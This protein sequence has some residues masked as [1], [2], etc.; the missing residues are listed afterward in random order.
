[1]SEHSEKG[2]LVTFDMDED[3]ND[4]PGEYGEDDIDDEL[5]GLNL[6]DEYPPAGA[7][8]GGFSITFDLD[9]D[10]LKAN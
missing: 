8:G 6:N 4:Q 10:F 9:E 5:D 3:L 7:V 1:M 2:G